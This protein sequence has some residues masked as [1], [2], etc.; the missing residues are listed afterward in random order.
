MAFVQSSDWVGRF[1]IGDN[2]CC[3]LKILK[4]L[5]AG[6]EASQE[7]ELLVQPIVILQAAICEA[8]VYDLIETRIRRHTWEPVQSIREDVIASLRR[9]KYQDSFKKLVNI[10]RANNLLGGTAL[11]DELHWLRKV[12]NRIHLQGLQNDNDYFFTVEILRRS[13][14]VTE[15]L[16]KT[17]STRYPREEGYRNYVREFQIPWEEQIDGEI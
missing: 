13:E 12:R 10:A 16:L 11:C 1:K 8:A 6:A 5:Y 3:S 14:M 2:I 9:A 7:P 4:E 17:M 15:R